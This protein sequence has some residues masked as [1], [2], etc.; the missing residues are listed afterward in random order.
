VQIR[1]PSLDDVFVALT[2]S[3][4]RTSQRGDAA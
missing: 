4:A 1:E 3:A 2:T